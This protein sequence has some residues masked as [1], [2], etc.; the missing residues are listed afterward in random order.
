MIALAFDYLQYLFSYLNIK[1][2]LSTMQEQNI[3]ETNYDYDDI[4]Y[5]SSKYFFV[6][7][8]LILLAGV[9]YFICCMI[10]LMVNLEE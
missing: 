6:G 5:K 10:L 1:K 8:Q 2:T 7:K 4:Y 3:E 9:F